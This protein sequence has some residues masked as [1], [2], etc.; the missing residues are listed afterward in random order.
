M[1]ANNTLTTYSSA[2]WH[3]VNVPPLPKA[4]SGVFWQ[5]NGPYDIILG[6]SP[7]IDPI[8][9]FSVVTPGPFLVTCKAGGALF[10]VGAGAFVASVAAGAVLLKASAA[11]D[12]TG[13]ATVTM[14]GAIVNI[15]GGAINLN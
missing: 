2:Q 3:F 9:R 6:P 13:G 5:C 14:K 11:V 4:K 15:L 8:P 7:S 10:K 1:S 12:I